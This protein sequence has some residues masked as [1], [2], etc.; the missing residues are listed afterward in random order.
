MFGSEPSSRKDL[1]S[2][3]IRVESIRD[4]FSVVDTTHLGLILLFLPFSVPL[5][6]SVLVPRTSS[7]FPRTETVPTLPFGDLPT[8]LNLRQCRASETHDTLYLLIV[9]RRRF[10]FSCL[11]GEFYGVMG[12]VFLRTLIKKGF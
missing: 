10:S 11:R 9:P 4:F 7:P 12:N 2:S 6:Q 3:P 1:L 5:Y 8:I